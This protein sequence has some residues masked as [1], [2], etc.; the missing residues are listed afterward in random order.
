MLV[1][2]RFRQTDRLTAD[3]CITKYITQAYVRMYSSI[4]KAVGKSYELF[5]AS[6]HIQ[7]S[8]DIKMNNFKIKSKTYINLTIFNLICVENVFNMMLYMIFQYG[9]EPVLIQ[10]SLHRRHIDIKV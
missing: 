6:F 10:R 9:R 5:I 8:T 7:I 2:F 4:H 3:T 1:T